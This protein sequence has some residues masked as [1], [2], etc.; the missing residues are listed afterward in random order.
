MKYVKVEPDP[1]LHPFVDS[2]WIQEN[3]TLST[4]GV[5]PYTTVIPTTIIDMI[6]HYGD[7]FLEQQ[8]DGD[9]TMPKMY[10]SGQQTSPIR[11]KATGKTGI[12]LVSFKPWG[13][14]HLFQIPADQFKDASVSLWDIL[15]YN[16]INELEEKLAEA[17]TAEAKVGCI[18][19]FLCN[20]LRRTQPDQTDTL[21]I[22]AALKINEGKGVTNIAEIREHFFISKRHFIRRFKKVMGLNPKEFSNIIRF[23]K[24]LL[25]TKLQVRAERI[26]GDLGYYD[27]SHMLH[28]FKRISGCSRSK[29]LKKCNSSSLK[30]AFNSTDNMAPFYN[31]IYL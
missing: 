31:T 19:E 5:D 26:I 3:D 14:F 15:S 24:A 20:I 28:E 23:Q 18:Q 1:Y 8:S 11:V 9:I 12:I 13:F 10:L 25:Y 7:P 30:Q 2:I 22:E 21:I 27:Q 29:I 16:E 17:Q 4:Q 6:F